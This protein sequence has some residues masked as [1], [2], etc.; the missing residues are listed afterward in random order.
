MP[1]VQLLSK[2]YLL[3]GKVFAKKVNGVPRVPLSI[4][5]GWTQ[6]SL[7]LANDHVNALK[8]L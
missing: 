5:W 2:I 3:R 1:I 4:L 6:I 7:K 8:I